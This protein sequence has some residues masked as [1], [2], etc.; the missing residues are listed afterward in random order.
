MDRH[1]YIFINLINF[2]SMFKK[3]LLQA[4]ILVLFACF[5]IASSSSTYQEVSRGAAEGAIKGAII[6]GTLS[7]DD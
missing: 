6:G 1:N 3:L 7:Y 5:A 4:L 2:Y